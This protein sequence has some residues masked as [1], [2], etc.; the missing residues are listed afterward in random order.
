L[1]LPLYYLDPYRPEAADEVCLSSVASANDAAE[2]AL[3]ASPQ[4]SASAYSSHYYYLHVLPRL[5]FV[6][7]LY[8]QA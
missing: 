8:P 1:L 2:V 5:W 3:T 6:G 4:A 7:K